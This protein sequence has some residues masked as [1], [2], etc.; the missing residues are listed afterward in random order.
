MS[1][2]TTAGLLIVS[3]VAARAGAQ[4]PI[5][6][7]DRAPAPRQVL[8]ARTVFIGNGGGQSFGA[9]LLQ[10]HKIRRRTQSRLR[11]VLF[12]RERLRTLR[13]RRIDGV[14]RRRT[15][16]QIREPDR[17]SSVGWRGRR[18]DER[19]GVRP[20]AKSVDQRSSH[21]LAPVDDHRAH[22]TG[23]QS[24]RRQ[25]PFRRSDWPSRQ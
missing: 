20:A 21:R 15:R 11:R 12:R 8:N 17:R 4:Q 19:S 13:H 24:R 6:L 14:G 25:S 10:S 16:H 23:Q 2:I 3:L 1:R 22:R 5:S 18:P 7:I 9:E